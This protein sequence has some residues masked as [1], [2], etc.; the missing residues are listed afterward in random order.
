[1]RE[2]QNTCHVERDSKPEKQPETESLKNEQESQGGHKSSDDEDD[3]GA[4]NADRDD[5][6]SRAEVSQEQM[7]RAR[8]VYLP[9]IR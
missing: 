3:V 5:F 2:A 1:M 8:R 6:L 7:L 4:T 9:C